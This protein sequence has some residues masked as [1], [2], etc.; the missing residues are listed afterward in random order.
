MKTFVCL[1]VIVVSNAVGNALL[2]HGMGQV[3]EIA[4]YSPLE[5]FASGVAAM[6]NPWVLAGAL[7]LITFFVTHAIVLSW[8]DL[9][10]VLIT[11]AFGYVAVALIGWLLLV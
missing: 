3:G 11:T 10:Y 9:S 2:S 6:A 4:S 1:A 8:A 7:L 5:L